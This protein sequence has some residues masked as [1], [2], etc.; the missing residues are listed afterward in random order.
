MP[1][2]QSVNKTQ[3]VLDY[4]KAHPRATSKGIVAAL[5]GQGIEVS[6]DFAARTKMTTNAATK[7]AAPLETLTLVQIKMIAQAIKKIRSRKVAPME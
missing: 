6:L 3:A 7:T 1:T 5:R 4:L 2:L